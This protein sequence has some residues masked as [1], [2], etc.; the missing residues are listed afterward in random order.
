MSL[1]TNNYLDRKL[2]RKKI[3][4]R[5]KTQYS[6]LVYLRKLGAVRKRPSQFCNALQVFF[7]I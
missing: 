2:G 3:V 1:K 5:H 7:E 6:K 4:C